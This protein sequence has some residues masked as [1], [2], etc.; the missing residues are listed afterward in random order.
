M[1]VQ[2]L[3]NDGLSIFL[4]M[5][6]GAL[7][8]H[9]LSIWPLSSI[10]LIPILWSRV[11]CRWLAGFVPAT[12]A[13]CATRG[14]I[15]GATIYFDLGQE[16]AVLLWLVAAVPHYFAGA[17]AWFVNIKKRVYF[18]IPLLCLLLI[19][20]PVML[21]GWAH[22]L[23][24][25]GLWFPRLGIWSLLCCLLFIVWIAATKSRGWLLIIITLVSTQALWRNASTNINTASGW[26]AHHTDF[27]NVNASTP[28]SILQRQWA[29]QNLVNSTG[30]HVFPE[31]VGGVWDNFL[32]DSWMNAISENTTILLG[33]Y[34]HET[35]WHNVIVAI[36]QRDTRIIYKQRLPM[37]AG[38]FN[39]F[40]K[41]HFATHW[42]GQSVVNLNG[43]RVGFA[44]CFEYVV[45]LPMLQIT[46]QKPEII[47]AP[48][49][50]WWSPRSLQIAQR[51][52]LRLWQ[53]WLGVPI[54][55]S[56]NGVKS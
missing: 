1:L 42:G 52:S 8:G 18:G 30:I 34:L 46:W 56:I 32:A 33:A 21:V 6:I 49:S 19:V 14:L 12:Y 31:S 13:L 23:L 16:F 48:A 27:H 5:I 38:M 26:S 40:S 54:I 53:S 47:V 10:I 4:A 25:A 44:L 45:L 51:Q 41:T 3:K 2:I 43:Q 17:L 22:P 39:P 37:T 24:A 11:S 7:W 28:L 36:N 55:E 20:P 9:S 15:E 29:M 35:Q 50:I